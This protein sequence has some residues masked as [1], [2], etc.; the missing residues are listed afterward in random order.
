MDVWTPG[1]LA[2]VSVGPHPPKG[3]CVWSSDLKSGRGAWI[4]P[5]VRGSSSRWIV[6]VPWFVFSFGSGEFERGLPKGA[7][8][9]PTGHCISSS[10]RRGRLDCVVVCVHRPPTARGVV[11]R[12]PSAFHL[13]QFTS[14]PPFRGWPKHGRCPA[15]CP[16]VDT[17]D[18]GE[19]WNLHE[20]GKEK[21][22]R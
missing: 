5:R 13:S 7:R 11:E 17:R 22:V 21:V 8:N 15:P 1:P 19:R 9:P 3:S 20:K 18:G 10:T 4:Q 16:K 14:P 2:E 6:P 12:R